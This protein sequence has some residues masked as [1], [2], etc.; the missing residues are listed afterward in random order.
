V[1]APG[2]DRSRDVQKAMSTKSRIASHESANGSPSFPLVRSRQS[3]EIESLE[4]GGR[5]KPGRRA[6]V[7]W[8][9]RIQEFAGAFV[10][11]FYI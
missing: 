5:Q 9:V 2:T 4:D 6:G 8:P 7:G 10:G 3:T 1:A 11:R